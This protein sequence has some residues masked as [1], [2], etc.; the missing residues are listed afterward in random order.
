MTRLRLITRLVGSLLLLAAAGQ[1]FADEMKKEDQSAFRT[2]DG[3]MISSSALIKLLK[4]KLDN[5]YQDLE[6][7]MLSCES[8]EFAARAKGAG[9]LPGTWSVT[10]AASSSRCGLDTEIAGNRKRKGKDGTDVEGLPVN[11]PYYVH[12]FSAQYVKKLLADKNTIGN[13]ALFEYARDK[14]HNDSG[15]QYASSGAAADA[16]TVHGGRKSN[17]AIVFSTPPSDIA[18]K[19][20]SEL[21]FA[22]KDAGYDD[23]EIQL[24]RGKN[25]A[26]EKGLSD[27]LDV[28]RAALD[29]NPGEEK[30]YL[31]ISAHGNYDART[32]A[33][34]DGQAN[35]AGGGVRLSNDHRRVTIFADSAVLQAGLREELPM[36]GGGFWQDD[37]TLH[38]GGPAY[39]RFTTLN[40]AFSGSDLAEVFLNGLLAGVVDMGNGSGADYQL[41]LSDALVDALMPDLMSR[42]LLDLDFRFAG[43]AD[44]IRLAGFEDWLDPGFAPLDYGISLGT[45]LAAFETEVAE[46]GSIVL[47]LA[48]FAALVFA[49]GR[50]RRGRRFVWNYSPDMAN[51]SNRQ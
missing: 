30:A 14:D 2:A 37:P 28:L 46:P 39:L 1:P 35:Q 42:G 40:E 13:K 31:S 41:D 26:T 20:T 23:K 32:V 43:S 15:P 34:A 21:R 9:G 50:L 7:V 22:L 27:A 11:T 51:F 44:H 12:G 36:S 10:T 47:A 48:G 45:P 33:Y 29:K 3:R 24:L 38:R 18:E 5:R 4:V 6:I 49:R 8:G 17:H 25:A 16:M 19:L